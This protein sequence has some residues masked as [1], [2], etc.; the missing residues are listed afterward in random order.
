[1]K[2]E[3]QLVRVMTVSAAADVKSTNRGQRYIGW[4]L[5]LVSEAKRIP[6]S[7]IYTIENTATRNRRDYEFWVY[8]WNPPSQPVICWRSSIGRALHL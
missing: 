8:C 2:K 7:G 6:L 1:M 5:S 3:E 4:R